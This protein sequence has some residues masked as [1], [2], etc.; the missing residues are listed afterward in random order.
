MTDPTIRE[1]SY[2][3]FLQE[4]PELLGILEQ[5]LLSLRENYSINKVHNLM[6]TTH[7]LKGAAA[8]VGL[9]T[10]KSVA[11]SLED[12]F[13]ALFNPNV[14]VD[15]EVEALLFEGYECLRLPLT[16]ALT[17]GSVNSAEILDRTATIFALL[18]E[19]L[20][21]CF[22]EEAQI[23][24]SLELGFDVTQSIF[25]VGVTQRLDEI[26]SV[27]ASSDPIE[28][29]NTLRTQAEVFLGLGESLN[30]PGFAA[31]SQATLAALDN[32][33]EQTVTIALTALADFRTGQVAVLGG[34]RTQGGQPSLELQQLAGLSLTELAV[35]RAERSVGL[36]EI[37]IHSSEFPEELAS[38]FVRDIST[39]PFYT[40]VPNPLIVE[41]VQAH[42]P[43]DAE[44]RGTAEE[45]EEE[46]LFASPASLM[47]SELQ[48]P[49]NAV[50]E[51]QTQSEQDWMTS[52]ADIG[53][54][55]D[56]SAE[57]LSS[58]VLNEESAN[59]LFEDIWGKRGSEQEQETQPSNLQPATIQ[60]STHLQE[61]EVTLETQPFRSSPTEKAPP[62]NSQ[63]GSVSRSVRVNVEHLEE[64]NY[65]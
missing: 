14:L 15:A 38:T 28:V 41:E 37:S 39:E 47:D 52:V 44:P 32:H 36:E 62:S 16:A 60:P 9:E 55:P 49:S 58:Q 8:S 13:K 40:T 11:H 10:I 57:D 12:I 63:K 50:W 61:P 30:L 31:I 6:R 24:S 4:A 7:T 18:Q 21:D 42:T 35:D 23:P 46:N 43:S 26:A 53:L 34:D 56:I 59:R 19:K 64:L 5:E 17:G 3:Y 22:S 54:N 2:R 20:G 48:E 1:Q 33:P 25:E 29:G 51:S 45:T 27:V 65:S